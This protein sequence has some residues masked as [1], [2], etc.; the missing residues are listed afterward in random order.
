MFSKD[1]DNVRFPVAFGIAQHLDPILM[2]FH[3]KDIAVGRWE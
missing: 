2:T 1:F 3:D